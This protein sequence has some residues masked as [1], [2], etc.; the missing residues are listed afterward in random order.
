M[1]YLVILFLLALLLACGTP[2][3][4]QLTPGPLSTTIPAAAIATAAPV[5]STDAPTAE[6][7]ATLATDA[8]TAEVLQVAPVATDTPAATA[9]ITPT[10]TL[11]PT[12]KPV[13][14]P[15]PTVKPAPAPTTAPAPPAAQSFDHNG[16]GK[17]T[18]ADFKTQAEA[19]IALAAGYKKLDNNGDGVPCESL[20]HG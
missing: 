8:P 12:T 19:K 10:V 20:P 15:K 17:V 11:Q 7:L 2:S 16:D 4:A 18:C 14:A 3:A 13:A 6:I 5:A 1:R 9:T